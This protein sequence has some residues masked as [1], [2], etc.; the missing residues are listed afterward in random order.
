MNKKLKTK[1]GDC[2]KCDLNTKDNKTMTKLVFGETNCQNDLDSIKLL[3]LG[4]APAYQETLDNRPFVGKAG[5]VFR[6]E[7][8]NSGL[9]NIPHYITNIV[10]CS[11][12]SYNPITKNIKTNNPSQLAIDCCSRNWKELI[13]ILC[14]EYI[15][16][17]GSSV[18]K[19]LDIKGSASQCRGK[20]YYYDD[21][22][23]TGFVPPQIFA[24]YHPSYIAR[25]TTPKHVRKQ[26]ISDFSTLNKEITKE[27]SFMT[28]EIEEEKKNDKVQK[29]DLK[30]NSPYSFDI[31]DKFKTQNI[32][33]IDIQKD[34]FN[35]QIIYVFRD[36]NRN[37]FY[38]YASA[39]DNYYYESTK[40]SD[41]CD[42]L[43][44]V[45]NVHIKFG[46]PPRYGSRRGLYESDLSIEYKHSIDYYLHRKKD[47][48]HY[49]LQIF[50][51]DIEV[52][53]YGSREFP[54]PK[55][56]ASPINAISFKNHNDEINCYVVNPKFFNLNTNID[57][58]IE[59]KSKFDFKLTIFES[60][61]ELLETFMKKLREDSPDIMI[62]WAN[63]NF[64]IIY[65]F[66]RI[67][68]NNLKASDL[69]P[70][71]RCNI[72][73]KKYGDIFIG[74]ISSVDMLELYKKFTFS[75][76]ESYKL[77]AVAQKQLGEGK[78]NYSGPLD[79]VYQND[80]IT[81]VN[82]SVQDSRL[83]YE[84]NDKLGH[85]KLANELRKI[86]SS[87]W[88]GVES[89]IGLIDPLCISYAKKMNIVCKDSDMGI[90]EKFKGA[91]VR[92]PVPGLHSWVV[93]MDFASMYP[94]IIISCNIGPDTYIAKIDEQIA[95]DYVYKKD[96]V[97]KSFTI[98]YNPITNFD[99]T[100]ISL[101]DFDKFMSKNEA[102][103]TSA[104]TIFI[105]HDKKLSF[106]NK[107]LTMLL[108]SRVNYKNL[109]KDAKR[110]DREEDRA[111]FFNIQM[112]YKI[113]A[114]SIYGALGASV[115]RLYRLD[116]AK[117]VTLTGR[118]LTQFAGYHMS[119]FMTTDNKE[120]DPDF[121]VKSKEHQKYWIYADTDSIF[122]EIGDYMI[123]KGIAVR[124]ELS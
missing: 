72:N 22:T 112:A 44:N 88:K 25:G 30:L 12:L 31:P 60:E 105:G 24:T 119:K 66:N 48:L 118:E 63:H 84:L 19:A 53:N 85:I 62:G 107:L 97:P 43:E 7:F 59:S 71:G 54:D 95:Y 78:I 41:N 28:G 5:R 113:L 82:Y 37:K 21:P 42:I 83:L 35:S 32:V 40:L 51:Y 55:I 108:D 120:I 36:A 116:L 13:N 92:D 102:I 70:I 121:K 9:I 33:L 6:A 79:E 110:E 14:P 101:N 16:A 18:Q 38:H 27:P 106:F 90:N 29:F 87:T 17:L 103:I 89:T 58:N 45:E 10:M 69:S 77:E 15:L 23:F 74:G 39:R 3:I 96:N 73:P 115:F 124:E 114:N 2:L 80:F 76:E 47:E 4:E 81:F 99:S 20:F 75:V 56:A 52:Y 104:G 94:N 64:D 67:R 93:D 61:K 65:I 49:D 117:S 111:R 122:L 50:Y 86:C 34:N 109:M 57:I 11:N 91:Y 123:D 26:F 98:T 100:T 8:A 68:K 46:H 1:F